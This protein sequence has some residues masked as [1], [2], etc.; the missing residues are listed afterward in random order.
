MQ[1]FER[2]AFATIVGLLAISWIAVFVNVEMSR[3][4]TQDSRETAQTTPVGDITVIGMNDE[5]RF[6]PNEITINVGDTLEWRNIG[7]IPHTVTADPR[8]MPS[9]TNIEL[10]D[11]AAAFDSGWVVRGES[12]RYTFSEPGIYRYI[13]LPHERAGMLGIVIV[14]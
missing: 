3:G 12:Y 8:R 14:G 9:S 4:V 1:R 13:C 6:V 11:G 7:A 5:L 10:P 2:I